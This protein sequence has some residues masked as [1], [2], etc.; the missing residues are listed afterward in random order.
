MVRNEI[1][2]LNIRKRLLAVFSSSNIK[3]GYIPVSNVES[4]C[5]WSKTK[6]ASDRT[7]LTTHQSLRMLPKAMSI[8]FHL[9]VGETIDGT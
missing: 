9:S 3:I 7:V 8:R 5:K 2:K 4:K 1:S 6:N